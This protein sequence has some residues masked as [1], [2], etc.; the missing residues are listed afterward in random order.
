M[1]CGVLYT[2]KMQDNYPRRW[3]WVGC[4]LRGHH[5]HRVHAWRSA[6]A[7]CAVRLKARVSEIRNNPHKGVSFLERTPPKWMSVI[8]LVCPQSSPKQVPSKKDRP[9]KR[10][11][12]KGAEPQRCPGRY[13]E[14]QYR[15]AWHH[16]RHPWL[17]GE[18]PRPNSSEETYIGKA[19][20]FRKAN[21]GPPVERLE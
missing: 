6:S 15:P 3:V 13:R 2:T 1:V 16:T 17:W 5:H 21:L 18:V 14:R 4:K 19:T 20:H 12:K 9:A 8:L 7:V 11:G 10:T